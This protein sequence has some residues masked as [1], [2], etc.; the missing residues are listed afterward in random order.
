MKQIQ[1]TMSLEEYN[2]ELETARKEG[3]AEGFAASYTEAPKIKAFLRE[4]FWHH[5]T[6]YKLYSLF[7][8]HDLHKAYALLEYHR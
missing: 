8:K 7:E 2:N 1:V 5:A 6:H 4:L 3:R